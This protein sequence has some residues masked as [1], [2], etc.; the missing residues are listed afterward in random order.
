VTRREEI[1]G[2]AREQPWARIGAVIVA[3]WV[4]EA[5]EVVKEVRPIADIIVYDPD[6][7][8][9]DGEGYVR[10][11][12]PDSIRVKMGQRKFPHWE[13][14]MLCPPE[15]QGMHQ[16]QGLTNAIKEL[17]TNFG[18]RLSAD[19]RHDLGIAAGVISTAITKLDRELPNYAA[20]AQ[21][22][23]V[24]GEQ[25]ARCRHLTMQQN[26]ERWTEIG[27][28]TLPKMVGRTPLQHL[29]GIAEGRDGLVVGAGP[30]LNQA[31]FWLPTVQ[32]RLVIA[33][34]EA[35]LPI[36]ERGGVRP[37]VVVCVESQD[38]A[39][40]GLGEL[41]LWDDAILVPGIHAA[42]RAW[43][44]P[45]RAICPAIQAIG[46]IGHFMLEGL[47]LTPVDSGGSVATVCYAVLHR[48][49]VET[50]CGVGIDSSYG[51]PDKMRAY[52]E[53]VVGKNK[54][55][56]AHELL[57]GWKGEGKVAS[58][59]QLKAYRDWFGT[60]P[61][62]YPDRVHVN[63]SVGGAHIPGWHEMELEEWTH[64]VKD[65]CEAFDGL[66]LPDKPMDLS[67]VAAALEEQL[68]GFAHAEES[69]RG[70]LDAAGRF[71]E[72][73]QELG[74]MPKT[75]NTKMIA[76]LQMS[77]LHVLARLPGPA[78][79]NAANTVNEHMLQLT[80]KFAPLIQAT[81]ERMNERHA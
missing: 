74:R 65:R 57:D 23:A 46:P 37:D 12:L 24:A 54:P 25:F 11:T 6:D 64:A 35:A 10:V 52:A 21:E 71:V 77:P 70:A 62:Q 66:K 1:E 61:R 2:W 4:P 17:A 14:S 58:S 19:E 33:A 59:P 26:I 28:E 39:Y 50:I 60:M 13:V 44:F 75:Q 76:T 30:S 48:L 55:P 20:T 3:G 32:D 43:D 29:D 78:E 34:T 38:H 56:K 7:I 5:I 27:L 40:D 53:G 69:A 16:F 63:L 41:S 49:G 79:M 80:Q 9:E 45:A 42:P 68:D 18:D 73:I 51:P 31:M 81:I 36:L 15:S 22:M 47:G 72:H 67:W 8:G